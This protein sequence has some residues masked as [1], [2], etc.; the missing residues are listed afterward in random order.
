MDFYSEY[1]EDLFIR[2]NTAMPERGV[3]VDCGCYHPRIGSNTAH[4]RDRGWTGIAIDGNASLAAAWE[5]HAPTAKF[6]CALVGDGTAQRYEVNR[7]NPGWSKTGAGEETP[8]RTLESI[9]TEHGIGKIDLLSID[10]E[11]MEFEALMTLDLAKHEPTVI[12]AE[13]DTQGIGKDFRVMEYLVRGDYVAVHMTEA[14]I[15]YKRV[16][17]QKFIKGG[18]I[19]EDHN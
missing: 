19:G 16:T 15:I 5:K 9:V 14:N 18:R 4:W 11:G 7:D 6:I 10:L 13:Y 2:M 3:Y 12:V 1:L 8:T 17:K